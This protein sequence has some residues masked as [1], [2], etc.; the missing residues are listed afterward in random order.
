MW[1]EKG[2]TDKSTQKAERGRLAL[3]KGWLSWQME[4]FYKRETYK[5]SRE[6]SQKQTD[7]QT[8]RLMVSHCSE[9]HLAETAGNCD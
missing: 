5:E 2:D 6:V 7:E 8:N 4:M 3:E 1:R 9:W